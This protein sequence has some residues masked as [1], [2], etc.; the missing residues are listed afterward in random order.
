MDR[1]KTGTLELTTEEVRERLSTTR[2]LSAEEERVLRMRHG[3]KVAKEAPLPRAAAGNA[4]LEDELL[5]LEMQLLRQ[6]RARKAPAATAR[7]EPAGDSRTKDKI[8][9]TLRRKK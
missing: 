3:G 7:V 9:R 8:V 1:N 4:E 5:V 6:L 2:T